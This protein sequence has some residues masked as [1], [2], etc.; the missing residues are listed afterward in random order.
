VKNEL[1]VESAENPTMPFD[2]PGDSQ[3]PGALEDARLL[4]VVAQGDPHALAALYHRRSGQIYSLLVR[5]LGNE[6]EAQEAMQ[7]A[8]MQIWRR[9][10]EYDPGRSVPM[11][12]II[13]IAR[14]LA[15]DRLRARS[16]RNAGQAAYEREVASLEVEIN[17]ARQTERDER[18]AACA[19]ALNR[20]PEAQGRAL[21]LAFFRGW[22]HEE[23]ACA[24]GEPLGTVKARIRRGLLALRPILKDYH[25]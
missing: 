6:M 5:M 11:A 10:R 2:R 18:A 20:L 21:Q 4:A 8:F 9:A 14:G 19:S 24:V 15:V 1:C 23:I 7:D 17:G 13:M 16:R 25:A 22:T 12:W 3:E